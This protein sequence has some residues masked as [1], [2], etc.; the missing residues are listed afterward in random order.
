[1]S[2]FPYDH[3][4]K[5]QTISGLAADQ[6]ISAIQKEIRRNHPENVTTLAYE[7]IITSDELTE[8]LWFRLK[9]IS[10]EDVGFGNIL[11]PVVVNSLDQMRKTMIGGDKALLAIHA[12]RYLCQ[13]KKDRSSDEMLCWIKKAYAA[14]ELKPEIPEYALD[15]HTLIGQLNGKDERHFYEVASN[16]SPEL[17]DRDRTY[18]ERIMKILDENK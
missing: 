7:M 13:S 12:V 8:Y 6:V 9:T 16:V 17:E 15:K 4:Q 18:R 5:Y 11:A 2:N 3:W 14:G 10:V 1:M